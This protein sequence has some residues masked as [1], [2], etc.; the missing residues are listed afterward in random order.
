MLIKVIVSSKPRWLGGVMYY[1]VIIQSA[2]RPCGTF[3]WQ[4]VFW[5]SY[6]HAVVSVGRMCRDR[7][8]ADSE[9]LCTICMPHDALGHP[10]FC[11][12]FFVYPHPN[13]HPLPL[14][15]NYH[16]L[17]ISYEYEHLHINHKFEPCTHWPNKRPKH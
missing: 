4:C 5:R 10:I 11:P 12:N 8:R 6:D 14:L 17:R 1:P 3:S 7:P 13:P 15:N 2:Y 9:E 16:S